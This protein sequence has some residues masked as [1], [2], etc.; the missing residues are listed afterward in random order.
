MSGDAGFIEHVS[1]DAESI[2]H[3]LYHTEI[4]K[5]NQTCEDYLEDGD[6]DGD[7]AFCD[8]YHSG[9]RISQKYCRF[10]GADDAEPGK[11]DEELIELMLNLLFPLFQFWK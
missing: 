4:V 9:H 5:R 2:E 3:G 10:G 6:C 8:D 1:G 11:L 7:C